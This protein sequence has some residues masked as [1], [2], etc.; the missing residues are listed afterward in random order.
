MPEK[1]ISGISLFIMIILLSCALVFLASC[2]V[3]VQDRPEE[4]M[5]SIEVEGFKDLKGKK[6]VTINMENILFDLPEIIIDS[7]TTVTWVNKDDVGHTVNSDPHPGHYNHPDL[8]SDLLYYED[9]FSYTFD[10]PG[11]YAYHCSPHYSTMKG[12]VQVE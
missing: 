3:T 10:E 6:E 8:N 9:T 11:L 1:N 4:N 5:Q 12:S 2:K 7:G